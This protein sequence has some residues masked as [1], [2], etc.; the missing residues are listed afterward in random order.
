MGFV[1]YRFTRASNPSNTPGFVIQGANVSMFLLTPPNLGSSC[2]C[3]FKYVE[4]TYLWVFLM[5][6]LFQKPSLGNWWHLNL[7]TE[8]W[9]FL[10]ISKVF[11]DTVRA[12]KDWYSGIFAWRSGWYIWHLPRLNW[13]Q[14]MDFLCLDNYLM[15][16]SLLWGSLKFSCT[17]ASVWS[18]I[19]VLFPTRSGYEF[20]LNTLMK[21]TSKHCTYSIIARLLAGASQSVSGQ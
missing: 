10:R 7:E 1:F 12:A 19:R 11:K 14:W 17:W 2:N 5:L 21:R 6:F 9:S 3:S 13:R 16:S 18:H 20:P 8:K 15:C 4:T